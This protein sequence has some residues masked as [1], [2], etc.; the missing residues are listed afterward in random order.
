MVKLKKQNNIYEKTYCYHHGFCNTEYFR[1][2]K[3]V[4]TRFKSYIKFLMFLFEY[5][6]SRTN[7]G[8]SMHIMITM[9]ATRMAIAVDPMMMA[10]GRLS[11]SVNGGCSSISRTGSSEI[12]YRQTYEYFELIHRILHT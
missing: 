4:F 10:E 8:K 9:Y 2:F 5:L 7:V 11:A 6:I 1:I 12:R 3:E